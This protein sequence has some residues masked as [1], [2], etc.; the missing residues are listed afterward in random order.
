MDSGQA[1]VLTSGI[2]GTGALTK[3]GSGSLA[4]GGA[5]TYTGTTNIDAGTLFVDGSLASTADVNVDSGGTLAGN[6]SLAGSV[7]VNSGGTVSPGTSTAIGA[8][9]IS[10]GY[11][12]L[13]GGTLALKLAG[14]TT[15]GTDYDALAIGGAASLDGTIQTTALNSFQPAGGDAYH[16][17]TFA[18][19]SGDFA[20]RQG[21]AFGG[22]FL[23]EQAGATNLDLLAIASP[24]VVTNATDSPM[25]GEISLRDAVAY[26]NAGSQLGVAVTINFAAGL[27]GRT[28][29][30]TQGPL[31]IG[32]TGTAA[33]T[34]DG[35]SLAQPVTI[36]G[37]SLANAMQ[38]DSGM[39]LN[40]TGVDFTG[41]TNID[42]G[43]I[44]NQGT[45]IVT[46]AAFTGNTASAG[47]GAILSTGALTVTGSTFIDNTV[48][49]AAGDGGGA[50]AIEGGSAT[51]TGNNFVGNQVTAATPLPG[52]DSAG[53]AI[54]AFFSSTI[55]FNRFSGNS[56]A[57]AGRGNTVAV[58]GSAEDVP[59]DNW[60]IS[61]TGPALGD[62]VAGGAGVFTPRAVDDFLVLSAAANPNPI[63]NG[64]ST[65]VTAGFT[66]DSAGQTIAAANLGV[67]IGQAVT[68]DGNT[69]MGSSLTGAQTTIQANGQATVTYN[70][71]PHGGT[72]TVNATVDAVTASALLT[73]DEPPSITS[74]A[75]TTFTVGTA[76]TFTI[77][78]S[79]FPTPTITRT[80]ALPGG[81]QFTEN[82]DGTATLAGTPNAGT[83]G[84]YSLTFTAQNGVGS[85]DSQTFALTVDQAPTISSAAGA[86]LTVGAAGSFTI[87]TANDFP[88]ATTLT[89][90]GTLPSGVTFH[91][92]GDGTATLS[93][94]PAP[95]TGNTYPLTITA[96]NGVSPDF[97]QSFTLTVD[98]AVSITSPAGTTFD[99]GVDTPFTVTALGFPQ[100]TFSIAAGALP[101]GVTLAPSGILS[102]TPVASTGAYVFTINAA[103]TL[104]SSTTQLFTLT[105]SA[106]PTPIVHA[107]G[108]FTVG[109][110]TTPTASPFSVT[111]TVGAMVP[112]VTLTESGKL[113]AGLVFAAKAGNAKTPATATIS[114]TP[115]A[116]TRGDYPITITATSG[117]FK[118]TTTAT[119]VV[120]QPPAITSA[121]TATL[122]AGANSSFVVKA[123]G[124]PF[125]SFSLGSITPP[126]SGITLADNHNGTATLTAPGA[127]AGTYTVAITA[128]NGVSS[129]PTVTQ[130]V[131]LRVI[132]LPTIT[133]PASGTF[134]VGASGSPITLSATAGTLPTVALTE[135]GKLPAGLV[136]TATP[137]TATTP[138]T[139]Q[140]TGKPAANTGGNYPITLVARSGAFQATQTLTLTVEQSPAIAPV[141]HATLGA[142]ANNSLVIKATGFPIPSFSIGS[143]TPPTPGI[144][145]TDNLN[146]TATLTAPGAAAGTY[147]L[148][149][150][151]GNGVSSKP[152]VTQTVTLR[153]IAVPTITAPASGTFTVGA[154]GSPI[155]MSAAAG[156]LPT[157]ALSETGKLPKGLVLSARPGNATVPATARITGTPAANTGGS[158]AVTLVAR[159]GPAIAT[160][161]L[162]LVVDQAPAIAKS[163]KAATFTYGQSG[164][165]LITATG[166]P[167]PSFSMSPAIAGI[168]LVDNHNGTATL[169][170]PTAG[171][172]G[173]PF[174]ITASNGIGAPAIRA[175]TLTI[176]Q[177]PTFL[178]LPINSTITVGAA[179]SFTVTATG[180]SPVSFAISGLLPKGLTFRDH[181]DG[182]AS[183]TAPTAALR[184]PG[185][186]TV[187]V[188]ASNGILPAALQ[189]F[190][191]VVKA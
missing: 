115:A 5:S 7:F 10:G 34:I 94:S 18:S 126:T 11:T 153:I 106:R 155:T 145:L 58:V 82:G 66:T 17:L 142:G 4:L 48:T 81:V 9:S 65:T 1:L 185:T 112:T 95:G 141:S 8:L 110:K 85:D 75:G 182:T 54:V 24:I 74:A 158:Y 131:T 42:G 188:T 161:T 35:S 61:N 89:E 3:I 83:G 44:F 20:T 134:T 146:G 26:A 14:N 47:G 98:E 23:V 22:V 32:P 183:L 109:V 76:G 162:T 101:G 41:G 29:V 166:F 102:G 184:T 186:F 137:G 171:A 52:A 151:A 177:S 123:A 121:A 170:A 157:V 152:T 6:G 90:T 160:Q 187:T 87:T 43:A 46:N 140:I 148:A 191:L 116:N 107:T 117:P 104:G 39:Q 119:I 96:H 167:V 168:T 49:G 154:S 19:A 73:I 79:G 37:N 16:V 25:P 169:I 143:I 175:F 111:A 122:A 38:V 45:L 181:H 12:Q 80:G 55:E 190:T 136:F 13:A 91:D 77:T 118:V 103:N 172:G 27:S 100:P 28:I 130:T 88:T 59:D 67:V 99:V 179:A 164:S 132:A 72:D 133:A 173:Y 40:L 31:E 128:G 50:I 124:F 127:A 144:T 129:K 108:T 56:D 189:L 69:A 86:T 62:V 33:I 63:L 159:S 64:A 60:W 156:T 149:I 125:P 165:L 163:V 114:G 178:S 113:P 15:P 139:A 57:A 84:I 30:L 2:G 53:G 97:Q 120:D 176:V 71:G 93:G 138:A 150:T 51:I 21:F 36:S 174:N 70:A 68:F 78:T 147:T 105:V 180:S 92:N 135:R